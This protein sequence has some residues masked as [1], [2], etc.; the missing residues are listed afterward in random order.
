MY[1]CMNVLMN[2]RNECARVEGG[3]R[4]GLGEP[5]PLPAIRRARERTRHSKRMDDEWHRRSERAE[6]LWRIW[7]IAREVRARSRARVPTILHRSYA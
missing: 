7:L 2:I 6:S 1:A 5:E 3:D 4:D